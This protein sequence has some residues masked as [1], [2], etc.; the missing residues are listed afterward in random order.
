MAAE[1]LWYCPQLPLE[2]L[3]KERANIVITQGRIVGVPRGS[4][5]CTT[6]SAD[7]FSALRNAT[8]SGCGGRSGGCEMTC[9]QSGRG[10]R[11]GDHYPQAHKACWDYHGI[12]TSSRHIPGVRWAGMIHPGLIGCLP[13]RELLERA[14]MAA[15]ATSR[16]FRAARA[17]TSPST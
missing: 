11:R 3:S 2:E 8:G 6:W 17:S 16:T 14:S 5:S 7:V 10:S 4:G 12:Y 13:N 9:P 1:L 15:T